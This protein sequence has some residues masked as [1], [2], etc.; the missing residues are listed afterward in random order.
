MD[1]IDR[2]LS[3]EPDIEPSERLTDNV[4]RAVSLENSVPPLTPFPWKRLVL[5][6]AACVLLAWLGTQPM[7]TVDRHAW[8]IVETALAP[9]RPLLEYLAVTLC[10]ILGGLR[11]QRSF[12]AD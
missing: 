10:L 8:E 3:S 4:M 1:E 7:A 2:I 9:A 11:L 6:S 5:G 12:T